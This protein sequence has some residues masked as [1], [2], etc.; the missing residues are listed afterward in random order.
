MGVLSHVGGHGFKTW[1]DRGVLKWLKEKYDITSMVDVGCGPGG[2]EKVAKEYL[3]HWV[4]IDGDPDIPDKPLLLRH[5]FTKTTLVDDLFGGLQFDL[6]WSVEFLEHVKEK[7]QSNY[8][9]VFQRC[10]YVVCTAA[11][12]GWGGHHHVNEQTQEYWI[13]VFDSYGFDYLS[14]ETED[15]KKHSTM[16]KHSRG[17][18][19]MENTGMLFHNWDGKTV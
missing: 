18:S 2:M 4:G 14:H 13:D 10:E 12:P 19:F 17:V 6:G 16:K 15:M 7:Y 8:M 5:D 3:I 11:P 9:S 1:V